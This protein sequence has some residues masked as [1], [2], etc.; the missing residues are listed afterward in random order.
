L[1]GVVHRHR[2]TKKL[3]PTHLAPTQRFSPKRLDIPLTL[4]TL[5]SELVVINKLSKM[6][7]GIASSWRSL[8][9]VASLAA[10][11]TITSTNAQFTNGQ[12]NEPP[13]QRREQ[14]FKVLEFENSNI[15]Q[16]Y[17]GTLRYY[18]TFRG[19]WSEERH[20]NDFPRSASWSA[21]VIISHSNGY[22]MWTGTEAATP[23]VESI[24][25]VSTN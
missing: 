18:C 24:A 8:L 22:R 14:T 10:T 7:P 3:A 9:L 17:P 2:L 21:P 13:G 12:F 11:F 15:N 19:K 1:L 25:E 4:Q 5:Y 23:G 20:P 6:S 16:R